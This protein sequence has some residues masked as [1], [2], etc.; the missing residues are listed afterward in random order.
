MKSTKN[1]FNCRG[2]KRDSAV[3]F[4]SFFS[5]LFFFVFKISHFFRLFH[6]EHYFGKW[7]LCCA[8]PGVVRP[9]TRLLASWN[10]FLTCFDPGHSSFF[11]PLGSTSGSESSSL[12]NH[13]QKNFLK[14]EEGR[15]VVDFPLRHKVGISLFI[16]FI[17]CSLSDAEEHTEKFMKNLCQIQF[18]GHCWPAHFFRF[19]VGCLWSD[20]WLHTEDIGN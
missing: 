1:Y 16:F 8:A 11:S 10:F 13:V 15:C 3:I 20:Q 7:L 5:R 14:S 17:S 12:L 9:P 18:F 4:S 2:V 6:S 19:V